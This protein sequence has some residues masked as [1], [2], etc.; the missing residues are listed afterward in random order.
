MS[1]ISSLPGSHYSLNDELDKTQTTRTT[2]TA[3]TP[4]ASPASTAIGDSV[5]LS[6]E[7]QAYLAKMT[8][9]KAADASQA[10][11]FT[12][13]ERQ[14]DHISAILAR[15]ADAPFTQ[16]TYNA[17]QYDLAAEGLSPDQLALREQVFAFSA[18]QSFMDALNGVASGSDS[19][20]LPGAQATDPVKAENYMKAIV[21]EWASISSTYD[22][23]A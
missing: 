14:Q 20:S 22:D 1:I 7:A 16:D 19:F 6:A 13:T 2:V 23:D 3:S 9:A 8:Q 21:E 12:L 11:H 15:Y 17:I 18:V 10:A 5:T 4:V